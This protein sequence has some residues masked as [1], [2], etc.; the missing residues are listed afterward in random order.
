MELDRVKARIRMLSEQEGLDV[1]I[2]RD[3]F[4]FEGFLRRLSMNTIVSEGQGGI[5]GGQ[6]TTIDDCSGRRQQTQ[7]P[8]L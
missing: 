4:F 8:H 6:K 5:S 1:Q 2:A 7:Y 3:A